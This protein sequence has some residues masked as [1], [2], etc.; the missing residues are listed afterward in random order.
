MSTVSKQSS[1]FVR[2]KKKLRRNALIKSVIF[3]LSCGI[4]AAAGV[5]LYQK[6]TTITPDP[7]L[8]LPVGGGVAILTGL[9]A[10]LVLRPSV[11]KI[12]QKLDQDLGLGE[13]VQTMLAYQ[14]EDSDML[15]LQREDADRRLLEASARRVRYRHPWLHAFAP[16]LACALAVVAVITPIKAVE[17][18]PEI[19]EPEIPFELSTWQET[20]LLELIEQVKASKME[21]SPKS[22][23]VAELESLLE[24]LRV[25]ST[26]DEMKT[27]VIAVITNLNR[28][29]REHNSAGSFAAA[30]KISEHKDVADMA[31]SMDMLSGLELQETLTTAR[32]NLRTDEVAEPLEAYISALRQMMMSVAELEVPENDGMYEGFGEHLSAMTKLQSQVGQYTRDWIQNQLDDIF[33]T[34][35]DDLSDAMFIQYTNK[36]VKDTT[37]ARLMEIFE[38]TEDDLPAEEK[39]QLPAADDEPEEEEKDEEDKGSQGGIGNMEILYGSDD[40][41]YDPNTNQYVKYGDVINAYYASVSEKIIDGKIPE[42]LE[43]FIADYFATLYDGSEKETTAP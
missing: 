20:A 30:M 6:L 37:V 15:R 14:H 24:A 17:E 34:A 2:F 23:T 12:A 8:Y 18:P 33:E 42:T 21:A 16:A 22:A 4:L 7:M 36:D 31:M 40:V 32:E 9:A 13:K 10:F 25:T 11:R 43:Q 38:L 1:G 39:I 26:E 5:V 35:V 41:I 19:E 28:V 3:G 27:I 29:I